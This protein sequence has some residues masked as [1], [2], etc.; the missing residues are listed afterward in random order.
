MKKANR[1]FMLIGIVLTVAIGA[2]FTIQN[3]L[4]L[5]TLSLNLWVVAFELK[6]PQPV[7]YLLLVGIRC[8][9]SFGWLGVPVCV[10]FAGE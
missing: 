8:G 2:L 10:E 7:P 3:S 4:R 9:A 1:W 5:T 6:D